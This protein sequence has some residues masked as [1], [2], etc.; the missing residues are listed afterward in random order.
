MC[1]VSVCVC[2]CVCDVPVCACVV[3]VRY[4]RTCPAT[5]FPSGPD[6]MTNTYSRKIDG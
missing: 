3:P 6:A 5:S 4:K 2:E 1:D